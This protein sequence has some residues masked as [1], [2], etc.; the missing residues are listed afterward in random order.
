MPLTRR[1][2]VSARL[3]PN[4]EQFRCGLTKHFPSLRVSQSRCAENVVNGSGV[5]H[6]VRII[7]AENDLAGADFCDQMS[8]TFGGKYDGIKIELLEIFAGKFLDGFAIRRKVAIEL[9]AV[10]RSDRKSVV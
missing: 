7:R 3:R 6:A 2:S 4:P 8:Q 1:S 9:Y 5:S 10:I